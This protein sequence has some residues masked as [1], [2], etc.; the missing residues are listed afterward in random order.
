M[1]L[2]CGNGHFTAKLLEAG[3]KRLGA[4]DYSEAAIQLAKDFI[5]ADAERN[6][7]DLCIYAADI[8]HPES[9]PEFNKYSVIVDKG[10]FD[11]I[12]LSGKDT[13]QDLAPA[14]KAT[15]KRLSCHDPQ[16]TKPLFIITSCNWTSTE[17]KNIFGP[18]LVAVDEIE[19]SSFTFG[20]RKGQ[21]VSTVIFEIN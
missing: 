10:T 19:H 4:L 13:I 8:L 16:G 7:A 5:G 9:I 1:D 12:S 21:D 11:A 3:F 20:G 6:D 15:L 2:G 14:F 18:E 17:L